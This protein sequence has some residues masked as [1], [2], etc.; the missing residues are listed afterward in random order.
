MLVDWCA[1]E[2]TR[3]P[4]LSSERTER[5]FPYVGCTL[6][7]HACLALVTALV[8]LD[9][10]PA[11]AES[12]TYDP[13]TQGFAKDG[14]LT[15]R[16]GDV[17]TIKIADDSPRRIWTISENYEEPAAAALAA[18]LITG[19]KLLGT[20][21]SA[22][23]S[24]V[25][26]LIAAQ[27]TVVAELT[28]IE[29]FIAAYLRAGGEAELATAAAFATSVTKLRD[30]MMSHA[31][32]L[33]DDD[34][35]KLAQTNAAVDTAL[36]GLRFIA[37]VGKRATESRTQGLR[38]R[39]GFNRLT[40]KVCSQTIEAS[41]DELVMSDATCSKS[42]YALEVR[43]SFGALAVSFGL[44]LPVYLKEPTTYTVDGGTLVAHRSTRDVGDVQPSIF[45]GVKFFDRGR[46]SFSMGLDLGLAVGD[47]FGDYYSAGVF[48]SY[49]GVSVGFGGF[50]D[51]EGTREEVPGTTG[52]ELDT[53]TRTAPLVG[54]AFR[55]A[56]NSD[57]LDV[58]SSYQE[59]LGAENKRGESEDEKEKEDGGST[60]TGRPP[61]A[62][63]D[64][65]LGRSDST[66]DD[67]NAT[68]VVP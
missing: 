15:V 48:A 37:R 10:R 32:G 44:S 28:K 3:A 59:Q 46:H 13:T 58:V 7:E 2:G 22:A 1:R 64:E 14:P 54:L 63:A 27:K 51:T 42:S 6:L 45:A 65:G 26:S 43:D 21:R 39:S 40:L 12:L 50:L 61:A 49:S 23:V 11:D 57:L 18:D 47:R 20:I 9:A 31:T 53:R 55:I 35:K 24:D 60:A 33:T 19:A 16:P 68:P 56:I 41:G 52:D 62:P 36:R 38:V 4:T 29:V 17:V 67:A 30:K 34:R 66:L 5:S 8:L 25:D